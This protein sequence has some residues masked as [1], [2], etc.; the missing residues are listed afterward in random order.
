MAVTVSRREFEAMVADALD[1][2][3]EVFAANLDNVAVIV[4]D[5][6]PA[7]EGAILGVYEGVALTERSPSESYLPDRIVIFRE[8]LCA[9]VDDLDELADEVYVTVLHEIGH[10]FGID[11]ERLHELGWG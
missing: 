4:E 6:P 9:M 7:A 3:P 2:L 8:P 10:Y 11:D 5:R 1:S